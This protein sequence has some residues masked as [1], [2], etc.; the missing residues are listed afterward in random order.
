MND[1]SSMAFFALQPQLLPL[2]EGFQQTLGLPTNWRIENLDNG[3][4]W[5]YTAAVGQSSS[6]AFYMDNWDY[7]NQTGAVDRL[8]LPAVTLPQNTIPLLQFGLAYALFSPS[9]YGDTLRVQASDDCGQTWATVYEKGGALLST[10][11]GPRSTEFVPQTNEWRQETVDLSAYRGVEALQVRLEHVSEAENNLYLDNFS[12]SLLNN[13]RSLQVQGWGR[14]SPN[15][16]QGE[17][18]LEVHLPESGKALTWRLYNAVGQEL[19]QYQEVA[20]RTNRYQLSLAHLPKGLYFLAWEWE[21]QRQV[22]RLI[23]R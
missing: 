8:V 3:I 16:T 2:A 7:Q 14:L 15:P 9:G 21:G 6:A 13:V 22:E 10:V 11:T 1:S 18:Q 5:A 12:I 17:M 4:T 19:L 23:L 20:E